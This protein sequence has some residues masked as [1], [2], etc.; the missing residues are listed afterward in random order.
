MTQ[1]NANVVCFVADQLLQSAIKHT[2]EYEL[3]E[4]E[5]VS[6][7]TMGLGLFLAHLL[8]SSE[9]LAEHEQRYR[10]EEAIARVRATYYFYLDHPELLRAIREHPMQMIEAQ[11]PAH[12]DVAAIESWT[13]QQRQES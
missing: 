11:G 8:P 12:F 1:F 9:V 10:F 13:R 4:P 7:I 5:A 2:A 6:A 3:E